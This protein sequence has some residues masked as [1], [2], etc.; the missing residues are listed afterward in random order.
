MNPTWMLTMLVALSAAFAWSANRRWQLLKVGRP[1]DRTDNLIERLKG[2]YEYAFVQ[3][4]MGNYPLAGLAHKMIFVGFMVLLLRS[5]MLWGRGFDPTF[6]LWILGPEPVTLPVLGAVPFGHIYEFIKDLVG[7]MVIFGALVFLYYRVV[8]HES[9][10]TLSGEGILILGIIVMMMLADM[11]YDGASL[12]LWH[13]YAGPVC[14]SGTEADLCESIQ[15]ITAHFGGPPGDEALAWHLYPNPAG[16]LM[17]TMLDGA[18]AQT[19]LIFGNAGFWIHSSLVLIF[20]NLLPHS[21]HFHIITAIPN[22][23]T[24]DLTP[25]GRLPL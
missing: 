25:P 7:S 6:S 4:K 3:K 21:K 15:K 8:K 5:V 1:V 10:M 2:T 11:I 18:G 16:S 13:R 22:V 23:F 17:A 20:A 24:R 9:R 12:V 14:A 19:L